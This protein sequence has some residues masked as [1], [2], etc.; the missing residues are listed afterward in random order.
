MENKSKIIFNILLLCFF[1]NTAFA[2]QAQ[3]PIIPYPNQVD[4]GDGKLDF[5][6]GYKLSGNSNQ[7][8]VFTATLSEFDINKSNKG[9]KVSLVIDEKLAN[10]EGYEMT[11]GKGKVA[12]KAASEQ[13]VF[14]GI[15]SLKQLLMNSKLVPFVYIKDQPAFRWRSFMLDEARHFQ[16]KETVKKLLDDMA[17]LKMNRF[18]WHLTNAAGW[19]IEIKSYPLL[20]VIGSKRDSTQINDEGKKSRSEKFRAEEYSGFYTQEEIKEVIAYA[21]ERHITI[22][23]EVT[24]PG[25]T[26]AAVASYPFLGVT[27]KKI[28]VPV[29][30]GVLKTVADVTDER[31]IKFFHDVLKE[32]SALFPSEYIHIGGDEVKFDEWKESAAVQAYMAK[33]GIKNFYDLQVNFTNGISKYVADSL[34]KRIIGW[35]EILGKNVHEWSKDDNSNTTLNKS[36]IVQFWKGAKEDLLLGIEE[37]HEVINSNHSFTYL[38]YNYKQISLKKAYEFNPIPEGLSPQQQKLIIG[39]GTQMWTEWTPTNKEIEYQV[40]PRLA[41]YAEI[42]WT[43]Q[44]TRDY[45]RFEENITNLLA[46]W[47][48]KN[49][50]IP[51]S[52]IYSNK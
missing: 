48:E 52:N 47:K 27:K 14:Y 16:G 44:S 5:S 22:I 39:T 25:H 7:K 26:A 28:S 29:K 51:S 15:Q 21:K 19:R 41:A 42:G 50:N 43:N 24:M 1:V 9:I 2:Q 12:I 30:F 35:N 11:I 36:A 40:Y 46:Y 4:I 6:K 32:V 17:L 8:E 20:T 45:E 49:Y 18:H 38:D 31:T 10:A 3:I 33:N 34:N 23:P 37:G 13:G